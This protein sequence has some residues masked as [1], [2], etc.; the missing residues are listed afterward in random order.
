MAKVKSKSKSKSKSKGTGKRAAKAPGKPG[1]SFDSIMESLFDILGEMNTSEMVPGEEYDLYAGFDSV[2]C[3]FINYSMRRLLGL[4]FGGDED[5]TLDG[6]V[7]IGCDVISRKVE[8]WAKVSFTYR[9]CTGSI[10]L[11]VRNGERSANMKVRYYSADFDTEHRSHVA[12][13]TVDGL[14]ETLGKVCDGLRVE[15]L[16]AAAK[17]YGMKVS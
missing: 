13:T 11:H 5:F 10:V 2:G 7:S 15:C 16:K 6:D 12:F 3:N 8:Y 4:A 9:A 17:K 1:K 14:G